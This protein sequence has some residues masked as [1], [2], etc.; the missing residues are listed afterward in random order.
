MPLSLIKKVGVLK[1]YI[2]PGEFNKEEI[3]VK[4]HR[5]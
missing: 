4:I 2:Q 3:I 1:N 5:Q